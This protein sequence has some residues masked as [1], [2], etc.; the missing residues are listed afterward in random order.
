MTKGLKVPSVTVEQMREVDRLMIEEY[1]ILLIQMMENAGRNLAMLVLDVARGISGKNVLVLAGGGNNG[2]GG[3]VA[4][5][6]LCNM[7]AQ[8]CVILSA[9]ADELRETPA[10][11]AS[12]LRKMGIETLEWNPSDEARLAA[13]SV[14]TVIVDALLGYSLSGSPRGGAARLI[15]MA[16]ASGKQIVALDVPSGVSATDGRVYEPAMRAMATVTLA[17]PKTALGSEEAR[18]L[19]GDL[20]LADISVPLGL[21]RRLGLEL[22]PLFA[23]GSPIPLIWTADGWVTG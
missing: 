22:A 13:F 10:H 19:S 11:Q 14:P 7:G 20:Y 5:R 9:A 16:N 12:V 18:A 2:G 17:L 6:H 21:Y 3:L 15:E 8:V 1:G 4:A 23:N